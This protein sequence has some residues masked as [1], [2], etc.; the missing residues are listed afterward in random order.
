MRNY[1]NIFRPQHEKSQII[2]NAW[3]VLLK[4]IVTVLTILFLGDFDVFTN[5]N[6]MADFC[7]LNG[8][9]NLINVSKILTIQPVLI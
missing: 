7:D 5:H 2:L 3:T 6:S 4:N 8:L 1:L 9:K